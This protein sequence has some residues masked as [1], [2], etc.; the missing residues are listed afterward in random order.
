MTGPD[1]LDVVTGAFSYSGAAIASELRAAGRQVRTLTG[2]P[3]RARA[4]TDIDVCPLNFD[5]PGELTRAMRGAHTLYNTYWVRFA[6]GHVDHGAA[7]A[8]SQTLFEAAAAAGVSASC[9]CRSRTHHLIRPI[10]TS[11]ARPRWNRSSPT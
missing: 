5:D 11:A 7:V 2:H 3:D 10:R 6:H 8:N 1:T 4:G 9:T